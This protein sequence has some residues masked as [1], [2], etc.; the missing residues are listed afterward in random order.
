MVRIC[1][2]QFLELYP[3][4]E[5]ESEEKG[6]RQCGS[7]IQL[8][9]PGLCDGSGDGQLAWRHAS[10]RERL[11]RRAPDGGSLA[12]RRR[13]PRPVGVAAGVGCASLLGSSL[14]GPAQMRAAHSLDGRDSSLPRPLLPPAE[15]LHGPSARLI[16]SLVRS[17][18][19]TS[20]ICCGFGGRARVCRAAGVGEH[21]KCLLSSPLSARRQ[22]YGPIN[23]HLD[24]DLDP[25]LARARP[26]APRDESE[27]RPA[28]WTEAIIKL[29]PQ[30]VCRHHKIV[31][32]L[33]GLGQLDWMS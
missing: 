22:R 14:P 29:P 32:L 31:A 3:E 23:S 4:R 17:R 24:L 5:R 15:V 27:S 6:P 25:G 10:A 18:R 8:E 28:R 12:R 30:S 21:W 9:A 7:V 20:F 16:V 1:A 13:P 11:I 33:S 2:W 19:M 26:N